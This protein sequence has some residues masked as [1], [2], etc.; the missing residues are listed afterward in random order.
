MAHGGDHKSAECITN[1]LQNAGTVPFI[2]A[3]L[4]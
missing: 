1:C 2:S 4:R 3:I